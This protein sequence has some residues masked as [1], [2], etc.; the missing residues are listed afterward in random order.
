MTPEKPI[1][2]LIVEDEPLAR[3]VLRDLIAQVDW[4]ELIGEAE[5]GLRALER[6]AA[7]KPDLLFLDVEMPELSGL[8]VLERIEHHPAVV[9]TTAYDRYAVAAF[10][11]EAIDYL[12]K[13]FGR[14]RFEATL[15]RLRRKWQEP[16]TLVRGPERPRA[17]LSGGPLRRLFARLGDRIVPI[18]VPAIT[19]IEA[20]DDYVAVHADGKRHLL[21]LTLSDLETRLDPE[22]FWRVHRSHIVQL[23]AITLMRP[24]DDR[25]LVLTLSDGSEVVASRAGSQRLRGLV[26]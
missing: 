15:E 4:L 25:R 1:R 21:N 2:A 24:Y 11:L 3:R 13:P 6:I 17:A 19:R 14:S 8:E 12:V 7:L 16:E 23:D 9:F 22:R 20:Y 5:D 10:E 18:P 26:G